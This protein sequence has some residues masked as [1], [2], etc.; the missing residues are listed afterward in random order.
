MKL[1]KKAKK[2]D[3]KEKAIDLIGGLDIL[4]ALDIETLEQI[5]FE[6]RDRII[7]DS[8]QWGF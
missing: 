6:Y 1:F 3:M 4:Q 5:V 2:A 7:G 8:M